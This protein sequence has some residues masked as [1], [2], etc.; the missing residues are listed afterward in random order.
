MTYS[1]LLSVGDTGQSRRKIRIYPTLTS[2]HACRGLRAGA[3][4]SHC[5]WAAAGPVPVEA[6]FDNYHTHLRATR[7]LPASCR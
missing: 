1:L 3:A 6:R 5:D 2:K 4:E 7:P